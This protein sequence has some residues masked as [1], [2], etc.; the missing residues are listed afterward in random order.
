M[1]G[2]SQNAEHDAISTLIDEQERHGHD[3]NVEKVGRIGV[4]DWAGVER[5]FFSKP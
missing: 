3:T 5:Y 4:I 1:F 2:F